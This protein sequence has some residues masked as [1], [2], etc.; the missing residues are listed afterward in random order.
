MSIRKIILRVSGGI[1]NIHPF[2]SIEGFTSSEQKKGFDPKTYLSLSKSSRL[3]IWLGLV[4]LALA[5]LTF[6]TYN[7]FQIYPKSSWMNFANSNSEVSVKKSINKI[8]PRIARNKKMVKAL[9]VEI[10]SRLLN[11]VRESEAKSLLAPIAETFEKRKLK[12]IEQKITFSMNRMSPNLITPVLPVPL[13]DKTLFL[14]AEKVTATDIKETRNSNPARTNQKKPV[15]VKKR[16]DSYAEMLKTQ[17]KTK[18]TTGKIML[19]KNSVKESLPGEINFM[20]ITLNLRGEYLNYLRARN[21]L[22]SYIPNLLIPLEEIVLN[23]KN[24]AIEYRVVYE[25]PYLTD[26]A[27]PSKKSM[28]AQKINRKKL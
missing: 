16:S 20:T 10:K 11:F 17:K 15:V 23:N 13:A 18:N 22:L 8:T 27:Q 9:D 2:N 4:G 1:K 28:S 7:I 3:P 24:G 19:K 26:K 14:E 6:L 5:T 12:I 25:L 21:M